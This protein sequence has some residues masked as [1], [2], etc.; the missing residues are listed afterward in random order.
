MS[1][2]YAACVSPAALDDLTEEFEMDG[3]DRSIAVAVAIAGR[4][5]AHA[6]GPRSCAK[7]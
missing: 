7:T 4:K 1:A 5:A 6:A 3:M 2:E